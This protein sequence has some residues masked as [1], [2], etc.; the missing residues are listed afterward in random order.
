MAVFLPE[1]TEIIVSYLD[2]Q[3]VCMLLTVCRAVARECA[4]KLWS[5]FF[6][7]FG[8]FGS[9]RTRYLSV[10]HIL[11]GSLNDDCKKIVCDAFKIDSK[12]L[13]K[14]PYFDYLSFLRVLDFSYCFKMF[15]PLSVKSRVFIDEMV[16]NVLSRT[17]TLNTLVIDMTL[18][19][20][21]VVC[22]LLLKL[23]G[24]KLDLFHVREFTGLES[25]VSFD[26]VTELVKGVISVCDIKEMKVDEELGGI[27]T[28]TSI[29][30]VTL[31]GC[32]NM[33]ER[34]KNVQEL[35]L[36]IS[37]LGV[38][39]LSMSVMKRCCVSLMFLC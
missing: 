4:R 38:R 29:P 15:E 20:R 34:F 25:V 18:I 39:T 9:L 30:R 1:L 32:R 37:D 23:K 13:E 10:V 35:T 24:R 36:H 7:V 31:R 28:I 12:M 19:N 16:I 22:P 27:G 11:F 14:R 3:S 2:L 17:D 6:G 8:E 21:R 5:D 26:S 33:I